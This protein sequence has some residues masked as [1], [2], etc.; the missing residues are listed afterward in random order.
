VHVQTVSV[1]VANPS[2]NNF[3]CLKMLGCTWFIQE[4]MIMLLQLSPAESFSC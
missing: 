1:T 2:P 3:D 4:N